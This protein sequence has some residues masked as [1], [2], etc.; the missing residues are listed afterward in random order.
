MNCQVCTTVHPEREKHEG[1]KN[2][3]GPPK[4]ATLASSKG[5]RNAIARGEGGGGIWT[6]KKSLTTQRKQIGILGLREERE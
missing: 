6:L 3:E 2:A 1:K 4:A 5:E